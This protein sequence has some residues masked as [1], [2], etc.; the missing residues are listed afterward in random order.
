LMINVNPA[1]HTLTLN[2]AMFPVHPTALYSEGPQVTPQQTFYQ[3]NF[4]DRRM[5]LLR[6]NS[7]TSL[8][9][10]EF[11]LETYSNPGG[12][13]F[14]AYVFADQI[15][16]NVTVDWMWV[17]E[18]LDLLLNNS[19]SILSLLEE[20]GV[21][22]SDLNLNDL[23]LDPQLLLNLLNISS[24]GGLQFNLTEAIRNFADLLF[25]NETNANSTLTLFN[26]T[27]TES[28]LID[29]LDSLLLPRNSSSLLL[30]NVTQLLEGGALEI[31]SIQIE[32]GEV[33]LIGV[34]LVINNRTLELGNVTLA[35]EQLQSLLPNSTE[36]Y[37]FQI[38]S[39][40]SIL[41]NT[42]SPHAVGAFLGELT[43][44]MFQVIPPLSPSSSSPFPVLLCVQ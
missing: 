28:D 10:S 5:D 31:Q 35:T 12:D 16:A 17:G 40:Y 11:M 25:G 27:F 29:A 18:N 26:Q 21:V 1:G 20:T 9:A 41:H 34:T 19:D 39:P 14:G 24:A 38:P 22:P 4:N 8:Q 3:S 42:S 37:S 33:Q 43:A 44:A 30:F 36:T 2:A 23:R 32:N 13:R 6:T 15:T 7:T